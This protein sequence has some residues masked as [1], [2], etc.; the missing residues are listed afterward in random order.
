MRWVFLLLSFSAHPLL[1]QAQQLEKQGKPAQAWQL[2]LEAYTRSPDQ[3]DGVEALLGAARA[4][5]AAGDTL[6]ARG[7]VLRVLRHPLPVPQI[8]E[9]ALLLHLRLTLPEARWD[10]LRAHPEWM[11][12]VP[13][14]SLWQ[15]RKALPDSL[16]LWLGTWGRSLDPAHRDRWRRWMVRRLQTSTDCRDHLMLARWARRDADTTWARI[17]EGDTL[18][19]VWWAWKHAPSPPVD[20]VLHQWVRRRPTERC[21]PWGAPDVSC[22][23]AVELID[24]LARW[25]RAG[26]T[27]TDSLFRWIRRSGRYPAWMLVLWARQLSNPVPDD[28]FLPLVPPAYAR[29]S[30]LQVLPTLEETTLLHTARRLGVYDLEWRPPAGSSRVDMLLFQ[31]H[32]LRYRRDTLWHRPPTISPDTLLRWALRLGSSGFLSAL[33]LALV[34]DR[35]PLPF[36]TIPL[37]RVPVEDRIRLARWMGR[38]HLMKN[39]PTLLQTLP[40]KEDRRRARFWA[41]L[42]AGNVDSSFRFLNPKRPDEVLAQARRDPEIRK[43]L[44]ALLSLKGTPRDTAVL[45]LWLTQDTLPEGAEQYA[46]R[47]LPPSLLRFLHRR[48]AWKALFE[49][50]RDLFLRHMLVVGH[51][52][53]LLQALVWIWLDFP[54]EAARLDWSLP[55]SLWV[56]LPTPLR[57]RIQDEFPDRR[58]VPPPSDSTVQPLPGDTLAPA[59]QD[60]SSAVADTAFPA[61]ERWERLLR[62]SPAFLDRLF[63]EAQRRYQKQDWSGARTLWQFAAR[64]PEVPRA[65]RAEA[66]YRLGV[67]AKNIGDTLQALRMFQTLMDRYPDSPRW[68]DAAFQQAY[69]YLDRGQVDAA[70][71][72]YDRLRGQPDTKEEEAE[73][74]YW[75]MQSWY[76]KKAWKQGILLGWLLWERYRTAGDWATTAALE[77]A[78]MYTLLGNLHDARRLLDAI[79]RVRGEKDELGRLAVRERKTLQTLQELRRSPP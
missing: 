16:T 73:R 17:C 28:T 4:S 40:G 39:L 21:L 24:T 7:L 18:A 2:Y 74:L 34:Q 33:R 72:V 65:R 22:D 69:L 3:R 45:R 61:P 68:S 41:Y 77:T 13:P 27:R 9:Q 36:R 23:R 37:R 14:E 58:L 48:L 12:L 53:T 55:E 19:A 29:D 76:R 5:F 6:T 63:R 30:L 75:E 54:K 78:R 71:Q 79:V 64:R 26:S 50:D 47:A 51:R 25:V 20:R 11:P 44:L 70:L 60:S 62:S 49:G 10:T 31:L 35:F 15:W 42:E 46:F 66:L 1:K 38:H 8:L 67:L 32:L 52:D 57:Q 59:N 56:R 43:D